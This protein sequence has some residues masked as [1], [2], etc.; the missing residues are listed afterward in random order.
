MQS[1]HASL[2][3]G[4]ACAP[5]AQT[6]DPLQLALHAC[7]RFVGG[8]AQEALDAAAEPGRMSALDA[9]IKRLQGVLM[10]VGQNG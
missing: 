10:H 3:N 6:T 7:D 5:L 2:K 1:V 9:S 8:G 4:T